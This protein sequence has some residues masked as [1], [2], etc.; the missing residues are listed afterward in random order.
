MANAAT[1]NA[2][3]YAIEARDPCTR[4]HS[5]RVSRYAGWIAVSMGLDRK[6]I[7]LLRVCARL[8]D[9]GKIG[10]SDRILLKPSK[11]TPQE[12]AEIERHPVYG[13]QILSD[14]AFIRKGIPIILSHHERVDGTGYPQR[15]KKHRLPLEVRI[16][17]IADAFDAMTSDRPYRKALPLPEVV[18][19]FKRCSGSQFDPQVVRV[20]L[21]LLEESGW[22]A[23]DFGG[24]LAA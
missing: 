16:I 19:E 20:F 21:C 8:H 9:V 22:A 7:E 2:L 6:K 12:R 24:L 13:A 14:L 1:I 11:L 17:S 4:G 3:A 23:H 10:V 15:L 5:E 18:K